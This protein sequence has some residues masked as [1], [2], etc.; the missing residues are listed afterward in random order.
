MASHDPLLL[1]GPPRLR[2]GLDAEKKRKQVAAGATV[3]P[4]PAKVRG[5][6]RLC[7]DRGGGRWAIRWKVV[8]AWTRGQVRLCPHGHEGSDSG[9]VF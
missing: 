7:A 2:D 5:V 9:P 8:D 1:C 6:S 3:R 4:R